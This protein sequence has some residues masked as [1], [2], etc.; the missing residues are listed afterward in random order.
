LKRERLAGLHVAWESSKLADMDATRLNP[1]LLQT[2]APSQ[3]IAERLLSEAGFVHV[4]DALARFRRFPQTPEERTLFERS[5]PAIL[6]AL[7]EGAAPDASLIN[8]ERFVQAVEDRAR[9]F[10]YLAEHP[11]AVEILFRL[12]V[13]S[14]FLTEI[15][16]RNPHYLERLT[17]H[18]GLAEFKSRQQ[19]GEE[20]RELFKSRSD[21]WD[22]LNELRRYQQW[23][24]LRLAA[25]DTFGLMDMKSVT[26]Q[27]ALLADSL[28]Q[29]CLDC[30]RQL[31]KIPAEDF[32]VIGFGK[33]GG[34]ELNY[35]SDIDLVFVC[36]EGADQFWGLGQKLINAIAEPTSAGFLYRVDMRLRPWGRSGPLVSTMDSYVEYMKKN[37]RL[38]EKQALLKARV[39]AGSQEIGGQVLKRLEPFIYDVDR[40]AARANVADMKR[41]IEEHL[42]KKG[43]AWGEVKGGQGSIRDVEFVTQFLQLSAGKETKEI[44]SFNTL[45][46]LVRLAEFDLIRADEFRQLSSGYVFL[47][48]IEHALQL[49]HNKQEHALPESARELSYLARRL[50]FPDADEFLS[51][52]T[53]HCLAIRAIY[54]RYILKGESATSPPVQLSPRTV[55][56]HFGAAAANYHEIFSTEQADR[57]LRLL[58]QLDDQHIVRTETRPLSGGGAELTVV[59]YDLLGDLSIM[60]GLL[61]VCGWNIESGWVFTGSEVFEPRSTS[62][63]AAEAPRKD[64][65]RRKFVNVF[66]VFPVLAPMPADVWPRYLAELQD[67][68]KLASQGKSGEAQGRLAK[69]VARALRERPQKSASTTA[70]LPVEIDIDNESDPECTVMQIRAED[71]VGFLYELANSLAVSGMSV[72]RVR[73]QSEGS[74]VLDTLAV[75]DAQGKKITD[76]NRL[77]ELRAAVVLTKHFT[78]LLPQSPNPESAL[79]QFREFLEHLFQQPNWLEQLGSLQQTEVLS[80]LAQLLGVSEFLWHDFLRLQH[81]NLFPVVADVQGLKHSKSLEELRGE[82]QGE[83]AQK[84]DYAAKCAALNAFKDREMLR[85]D[86]RHILNLQDKFVEFSH[87]LTDVAEAVVDANYKLADDELRPAYGRPLLTGRPCRIAVCALGKAGGSELGYAS[88]IE[89]MFIYEGDGQTSGPEKISNVEF[90]QKLVDLFRGSIDARRKGIFEVD[91]RL[92]PYG[93][94]GSLAV[95]L[96]TFEKYF[97]PEGAAWPYERQALVKLRPI[98]GDADFGREVASARD[99]MIYTGRP[100]DVAAMRGMREKQNRQLVRAGTFNAKLSPGGLVDCEYLVQGLQITYGDRDPSL[101]ETNTREAMK[102]LQ[103]AGILTPSERLRLRDTYRFLRRLIDGLRMVR[104]DARDLAVPPPESEEFEFLARR[105]GYKS[106]IGQLARDLEEHTQNVL[107]LTRLLEEHVAHPRTIAKHA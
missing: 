26:L 103:N 7:S 35:S 61:F 39:I 56:I 82:L 92:R 20:G 81:E 30:S 41:R 16:L 8:L 102:A 64:D 5:L 55:D 98:A 107:E 90:Y 70:L 60:S 85:V 43:R 83:I 18:K 15:L 21:F 87:E 29:S 47:R 89:L 78:H 58:D 68:L 46:A 48:T 105:M 32:A 11:R 45:D 3:A 4:A 12:F 44:R 33:L 94:A 75:V 2:D 24:L 22:Q 6:V 40:E 71:T 101:R 66:H 38:W 50:D 37:G 54:D 95:S 96:D 34:E 106:D 28:V 77:S 19:F 13:G 63:E 100:F 99:A 79:V 42:E 62:G 93:K 10:R 36:R 31:L 49:M 84:H 14:Q 74:E 53:Q 88:D 9:L 72:H 1:P 86:M 69:R 17:Q 97:G 80:A 65:R 52:Y 76:S 73:I 27:L 23:E 57:H 104:G 67:L 91:L 51:H 25:C 59:G